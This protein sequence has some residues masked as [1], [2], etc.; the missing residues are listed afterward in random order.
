MVIHFSDMV[1]LLTTLKTAL[2]GIAAYFILPNGVGSAKFLSPEERQFAVSRLNAASQS[3]GGNREGCVFFSTTW[4]Y[5]T[6]C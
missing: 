6:S 5:V 3:G 1:S 2:V 4:Y